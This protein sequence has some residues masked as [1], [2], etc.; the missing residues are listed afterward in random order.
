MNSGDDL[1]QWI[2]SAMEP[3]DL[4]SAIATF[5]PI[6]V[7]KPMPWR[8]MEPCE[9]CPTHSACDPNAT[10][11]LV[12]YQHWIET[13]DGQG[14][15][16]HTYTHRSCASDLEWELHQLTRPDLPRRAE[17]LI[18]YVLMIDNAGGR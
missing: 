8:D 4:L 15:Y 18:V 12:T 11:A 9:F 17:N 16:S 1:A 13:T 6:A 10:V 3:T 2:N 7:F 5:D 14:Y